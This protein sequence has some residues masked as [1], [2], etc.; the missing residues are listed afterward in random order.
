M[1]GA[2]IASTEP[3][4]SLLGKAIERIPRR[5]D[6]L[7]NRAQPEFTPWPSLA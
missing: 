1:F 5:Q 6:L 2:G 3:D 7:P 4:L